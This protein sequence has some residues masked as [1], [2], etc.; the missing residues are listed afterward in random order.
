MMVEVIIAY[1]KVLSQCSTGSN[2]KINNIIL[3]STQEEQPT[4]IKKYMSFS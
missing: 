2:E 4:N 3:L 1:S